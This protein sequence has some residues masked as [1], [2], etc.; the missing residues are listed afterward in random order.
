MRRVL[1]GG[2]GWER[3][4]RLLRSRERFGR[5]E[6]EEDREARPGLKKGNVS[7]IFSL[8]VWCVVFENEVVVR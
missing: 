6:L 1:V 2:E 3:G 4:G 8:E 7:I 5:E